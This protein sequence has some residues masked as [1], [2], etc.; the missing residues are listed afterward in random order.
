M[1]EGASDERDCWF[2]TMAIYVSNCWTDTNNLH[3]I[4]FA[5]KLVS[6]KLSG[7][8]LVFPTFNFVFCKEV[9]KKSLSEHPHLTYLKILLLLS[10]F[11]HA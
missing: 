9:S 1:R 2:T 3:D 4:H 5:L 6:V 11:P 8:A 7:L 10:L